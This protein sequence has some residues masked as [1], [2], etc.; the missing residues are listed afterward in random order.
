[1]HVRTCTGALQ[2]LFCI[3]LLALQSCKE[4]LPVYIDPR[5]VFDAYAYCVYSVTSADHSVKVYLT[6]VNAY[7]ETFE[8]DAVLTGQV[9]IT[10]AKDPTFTKTVPLVPADVK[11]ARNYN[12]VTGVL[13]LDAGD[14]VRFG[15]SWDM[16]AEDGR[17]LFSMYSFFPDPECPA[18][19]LSHEP[20][21]LFVGGDAALYQRTGVAR[22]DRSAYVFRLQR[23]FVLCRPARQTVPET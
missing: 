1:M 5:D 12:T 6:I 22:T 3:G 19:R 14:S 15:I 7:D 17:S 11:Y 8:A 10:L 4:P 20:V 2:A 23:E 13:R 18:R 21:V 9:T 16:V